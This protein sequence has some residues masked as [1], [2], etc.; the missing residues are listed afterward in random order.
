MKAG[1]RAAVPWLRAPLCS[2]RVITGQKMK[3]LLVLIFQR[4]MYAVKIREMLETCVFLCL[5]HPGLNIP[6]K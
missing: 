4:S 5:S 1:G 2:E 6:N 3:R